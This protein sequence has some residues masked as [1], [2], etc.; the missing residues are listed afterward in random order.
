MSILGKIKSPPHPNLPE[1]IFQA[2]RGG[3]ILKPP[4]AGILHPSR[5]LWVTILV[6]IQMSFSGV[7]IFDLL[8]SIEIFFDLQCTGCRCPEKHAQVGPMK[9]MI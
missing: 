8:F 4:A 1:V 9:K 5:F 7:K 6:G 2:E 3:Y